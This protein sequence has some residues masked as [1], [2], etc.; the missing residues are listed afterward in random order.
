M[1]SKLYY[2]PRWKRKVFA[3]ARYSPAILCLLLR[4]RRR[5]KSF[6]SQSFFVNSVY[7]QHPQD[8]RSLWTA[9]NV[10][11]P[12]LGQ[13]CLV[14]VILSPSTWYELDFLIAALGAAAFA[15][16]ITPGRVHPLRVLQ[17]PLPRFRSS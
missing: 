16:R 7:P 13:N 2:G 8:T 3:G 4:G 17:G 5:M 11:G 15:I 10:P 14:L 9:M 6:L 12:H 1:L